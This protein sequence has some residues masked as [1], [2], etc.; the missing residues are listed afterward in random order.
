MRGFSM[1]VILEAQI[2]D[3]LVNIV[4]FH[5]SPEGKPFSWK[6]SR[7]FAVG[8]RVRYEDFYAD[9]H[10]KN[11]PGLGW[12]V[13]VKAEDGK[14]YAATQTHFVTEECW[15]GLKAHFALPKNRKGRAKNGESR[16]RNGTPGRRGAKT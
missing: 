6:T 11:H 5:A 4:E 14:R 13:I 12:M 9:Q 1:S 7:K 8:E 15:Q 3:N 10:Y 2:G 16:V